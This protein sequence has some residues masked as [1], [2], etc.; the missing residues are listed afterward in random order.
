MPE[1]T[2]SSGVVEYLRS[3]STQIAESVGE[4]GYLI[5]D[6]MVVIVLGMLL[7]FVLH[8]IARRFL[9]PLI[10]NNRLPVVMFGTLYV[11]VLVVTAIM[12]LNKMGFDVSLGG[13]LA[14]M[15]VLF[16]AVVIYFLMPFLPKLPFKPG[17]NI[18]TQGVF[19]KV[20][21]V[22][23]LHTTVRKFDGTVAFLPN[24]MILAGKILNYTYD[25]HRRIEMYLSVDPDCHME[26]VQERLT[27]MMTED[28]RVLEDPAPTVYASGADA[29]GVALTL[30]CWTENTDFIKT[31][32]ALWFEFIRLAHEDPDIRLAVP[33]QQVEVSDG[34]AL[35][36]NRITETTED[37]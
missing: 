20:T 15:L 21:S 34:R 30:Y 3:N 24:P 10:Q 29:N 4:Y 37:L 6:S 31:R 11:L 5:G 25:P 1:E 33:K 36:R 18:E 19:G 22:S 13:R 9:F 27:G 28:H 32:S 12:V 17:H 14:V 23:Y 35:D 26:A 2:T 16:T 7:V 8:R